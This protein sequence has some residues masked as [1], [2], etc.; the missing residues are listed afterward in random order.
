MKNILSILL[1][2]IALSTI[3]QTGGQARLDEAVAA[4]EAGN[5]D[6]AMARV[7]EAL[8]LSPDLAKAYKLRG[9]IHQRQKDLD[10]A[11]Q[12]YKTSEK[13]DDTDPRLFVSRSALLITDGR[14]SAGLREA[15][16]ALDLDPKD[17]DA[18]YDRS[19]AQYLG[20]DPDAAL[21][22]AKKAME[23][24]PD[25]ADALYL[26]GVVK[27]EQND[28]DEGLDDIARALS[29]KPSIPGGLMSE[30]VLLFESRQYEAAIAKFN[31][32]IATDTTELAQAHYYRADSYYNLDDKQ[33][34]CIDWTISA[35]LGD[36][37]AAYI[38][39]TY[40][41]TDATKIPKKP[42]RQRRKTSIQF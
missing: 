14:Y 7:Q 10:A 23:I 26:M 11:L 33:H 25:H 31:Q 20:G 29:M 35:R 3:A 6:S 16:K 1:A 28:E 12:D 8:V 38:K 13:L 4:Y 39:R 37:D 42:K 36:K 5:L 24:R 40:C 17:A 27:G 30:G 15:D 21:K 2:S 32:V 34:A 9:D 19:C 41:E 22:S 18:W